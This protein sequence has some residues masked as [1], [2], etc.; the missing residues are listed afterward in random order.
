MEQKYA[1]LMMIHEKWW[2]EFCRRMNEGKKTHS[3]VHKGPAPPKDT[4]LLLFYVAE[5]RAEIA[6]HAKFLERQVGDSTEMWN[7]F[8]SESVLATEKS[9]YEFM[10]GW[11]ESTFTR[12]E[13]LHV[14]QQPIC[15]NNVLTFLGTNRLPR[16][17]LYLDK[18]TTEQFVTLMK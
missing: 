14:A 11:E 18:E 4:T 6:G 5:P 15:R 17:G 16:K 3:Y 1:Y 7:K 10:K 8:G 2:S 12:F 9:Y 13:D